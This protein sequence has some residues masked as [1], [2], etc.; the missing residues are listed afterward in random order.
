MLTKYLKQKAINQA[1]IC[2]K[3]AVVENRVDFNG[4]PIKCYYKEEKYNPVMSS[5]EYILKKLIY[6]CQE[7]DTMQFP[8]S[9]N[10]APFGCPQVRSTSDSNRIS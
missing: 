2:N 6:K 7:L 10:G 8:R 9:L 4:C 3:N 5:S 1:N